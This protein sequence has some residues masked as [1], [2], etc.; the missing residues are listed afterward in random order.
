MSYLVAQPYRLVLSLM[1]DEFYVE[2]TSGKWMYCIDIFYVEL[3][4]GER[5]YYINVFYL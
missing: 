4:S 5:V 1:T 2:P 3:T